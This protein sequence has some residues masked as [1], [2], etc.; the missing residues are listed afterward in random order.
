[1][2]IVLPI[3]QCTGQNK[4]IPD[5][6]M[7]K[8]QPA[9]LVFF[10]DIR[11]SFVFSDLTE[12]FKRTTPVTVYGAGAGVEFNRA[13]LYS[14]GIY[15][16]TKNAES[17]LAVA[18]NQG[19]TSLNQRWAL[20]FASLH[21]TYTF[22]NKKKIEFQLPFEIGIGRG[23]IQVRDNFDNLIVLEK[24]AIIPFQ[25][26][27]YCEWK[28]TKYFGLRGSVGYRKILIGKIFSRNFDSPYYSFGLS[29][30]LSNIREGVIKLFKKKKNLDGNQVKPIVPAEIKKKNIVPNNNNSEEEIPK[31][32]PKSKLIW[33]KRNKD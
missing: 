15:A 21:Y 20:T 23:K 22:Y 24:G 17:R 9:A 10:T 8:D 14:L 26:G 12:F 28:L 5:T 16:L 3:F 6:L 1:M 18:N 27:F 7:F 19:I 2:L 31:V 4:I 29:I 32:K 11:N 30:Y 33:I 25:F 13:H